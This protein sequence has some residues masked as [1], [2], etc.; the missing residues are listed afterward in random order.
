VPKVI[1]ATAALLALW[2]PGP[3]SAQAP[4]PAPAPAPAAEVQDLHTPEGQFRFAEGLFFRK[5]YDLAE[6]E[7]QA[8]GERYPTHALAPDAAYRLVLCLRQQKKDD[9]MVAA[10]DRFQASWATHEVS[11]RLSLWKGELLYGRKDYAGAETCFRRLMESADTV[12]REAAT[13][14]VG[15]CLE[16]QG[17]AAEA[18][19][20][21]GVLAE[22]PFDAAHSYRP[23]ALYALAIADQR[24][25]SNDSAAARFQRLADGASPA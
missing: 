15:R 12:V 17:K 18:L 13:Y 24:R 22:S 1:A 25:G 19:A 11:A 3:A 8:F 10:I 9:A 20:A 21:Y 23:Y 5:F 2:A 14:F 7:F 6:K 16:E 4:A